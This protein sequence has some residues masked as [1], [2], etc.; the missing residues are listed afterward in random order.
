MKANAAGFPFAWRSH[1]SQQPSSDAL[2]DVLAGIDSHRLDDLPGFDAEGVTAHRDLLERG[3][4]AHLAMLRKS[5]DGSMAVLSPAGLVVCWYARTGDFQRA[6][7]PVLERHVSQ[8]YLAHDIAERL[9]Q[10]HLETATVC[11]SSSRDGWRVSGSGHRFWG[12]TRIRVLSGHDGTIEGFLHVIRPSC[13]SREGLRA[14]A[15]I[16]WRDAA[17]VPQSRRE[18]AALSAAA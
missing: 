6:D 8:F 2:Y 17:A 18:Y 7:S 1:A 14:A 5:D 11:G 4:R 3:A 16:A 13:G 12:T 15:P 9:P 10:R